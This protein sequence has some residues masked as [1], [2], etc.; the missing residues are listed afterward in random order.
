MIFRDVKPQNILLRQDGRVKLLDLGAA[1]RMRQRDSMAG[2]PGYA[3]PEQLLP[4][5]PLTPASDVYGVGRTLQA[6]AG[7]DCGRKLKNLLA[8]CT[9][10]EP[11]RRFPDMPSLRD[12]LAQ[13]KEISRSVCLE[14]LWETNYK[15]DYDVRVEK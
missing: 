6:M 11:G 5:A 4:G 2:T 13:K 9:R 10:T 14:N 7:A 3:A 8:R 1:C 12:A 15:Q